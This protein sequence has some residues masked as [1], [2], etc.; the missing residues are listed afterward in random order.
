[1][2]EHQETPSTATP[3]APAPPSEPQ[4]DQPAAQP[5]A[6]VTS[7]DATASVTATAAA[8]TAAV[9]N[10]TPVNGNAARP[11]EELSCMWQGCTEKSPSAEALYVSSSFRS[12]S[13]PPTQSMIDRCRNM[14]ANATW[15]ARAPTTST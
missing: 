6:Q 14:C 3:A 13:T 11:S 10:A 9:A 5:Q 1:M 12:T 7:A 15:V 4:Q 8:A 2:S